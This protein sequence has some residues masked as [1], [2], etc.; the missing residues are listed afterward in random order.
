MTG[1]NSTVDGMIKSTYTV[2]LVS[3][4]LSPVDLSPVLGTFYR[5]ATFY[6]RVDE[7]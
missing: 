5:L 4:K 2:G 6:F 1:H 7:D 3:S